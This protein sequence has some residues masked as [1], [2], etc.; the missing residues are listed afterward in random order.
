M[1]LTFL[2]VFVDTDTCASKLNATDTF[3]CFCWYWHLCVDP[4][5]DATDI[6]VRFL[7][8]LTHARGPQTKCN[9]CFCVLL[10]MLTHARG[11][12]QYF[13]RE[14]NTSQDMSGTGCVGFWEKSYFWSPPGPWMGPGALNP[15][16]PHFFSDNLK[17]LDLKRHISDKS[18]FFPTN[19]IFSDKCHFL[20]LITKIVIWKNK[21]QKLWFA[22][23]QVLDRVG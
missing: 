4:K 23:L 19:H 14:G 12:Y 1:Q 10:L 13:Q 17:K 15:D 8:M 18:H 20:C 2:C 3:V 9:F 11:P 16:K 21:S 7:L 6:V 5:L 22:A